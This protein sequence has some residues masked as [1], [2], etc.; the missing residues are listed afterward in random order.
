MKVRMDDGTE[1][2]RGPGDTAVI[3]PGHD[4]LVVGDELCF[5]LDFTGMGNYT[6]KPE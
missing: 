4:A 2:E 1:F 3:P 6:K 5:S